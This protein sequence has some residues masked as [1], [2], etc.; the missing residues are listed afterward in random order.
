MHI[1]FNQSFVDEYNRAG[2]K[3]MRAEEDQAKDLT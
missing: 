1:V 2:I 3:E